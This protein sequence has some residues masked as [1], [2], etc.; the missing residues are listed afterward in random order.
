MKKIF[1]LLT[2]A[3]VFGVA[4]SCTDILDTA[5]NDKLSSGTMWTTEESVDQG[6]IGVYYSLQRPFHGIKLLVPMP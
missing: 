6:V 3:A 4:T 2:L 1:N 5:P